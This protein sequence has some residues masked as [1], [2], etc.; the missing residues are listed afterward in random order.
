MGTLP[1]G[2]TYEGTSL[3][4]EDTVTV[5]HFFKLADAAGPYAFELNGVS[6]VPQENGPYYTVDVK[7]IPF[8]A[9]GQRHIVGVSA[10]S[11]AW[12]MSY[13]PL[14]Y[15]QRA[16]AQQAEP[17]LSTLM[18]AMCLYYFSLVVSAQ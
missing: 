17:S 6:A 9:L 13:C 7:G 11:S 4:L 12:S 10:G 1:A 16:L 14:S 8:A 5:R 15:A 18:Q 3:I 2:V